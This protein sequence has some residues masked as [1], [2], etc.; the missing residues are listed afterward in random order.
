MKSERFK[1]LTLM[2]LHHQKYPVDLNA[3]IDTFA[4]RFKTKMALLPLRLLNEE[5][6]DEKQTSFGMNKNRLY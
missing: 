5:S 1:G 2:K 3:A 4:R 6:V